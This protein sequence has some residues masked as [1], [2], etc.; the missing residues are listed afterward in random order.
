MDTGKQPPSKDT[1]P[2]FRVR[3]ARA[4]QGDAVIRMKKKEYDELL[5]KEFKAALRYI[6][7]SD[8]E[9]I[10][11]SLPTPPILD[12]HQAPAFQS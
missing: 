4:S 8:G 9:V 2:A 7:E 6:D 10:L 12:Q 3:Q 11:V 1:L 5:L